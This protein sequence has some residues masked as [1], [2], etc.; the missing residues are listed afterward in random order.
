MPSEQDV[1]LL[2][3]LAFLNAAMLPDTTMKAF[4]RGKLIALSDSKKKLEK[5][6]TSSLTVHLKALNQKEANSPKRS[7]WQEKI[8]LRGKIN[9]V[10]KKKKVLHRESTKPGAVF[11]FWFL[12]LFFFRKSTRYMNP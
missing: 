10:G 2:A 4:L 11:G 8:K 6:Y 9:Q 7:R 1:K 12:F 3:P 5:A